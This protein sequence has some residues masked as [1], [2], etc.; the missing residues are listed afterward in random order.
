MPVNFEYSKKHTVFNAEAQ[1]TD[2]TRLVGSHFQLLC[3]FLL[4]ATCAAISS[5]PTDG[6]SRR[7]KTSLYRFTSPFIYRRAQYNLNAKYPVYV[8][9]RQSS[10]V[11]PV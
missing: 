1:F 9:R 3:L 11:F 4:K 10:L 5:T 7:D 6:V 2:L 8:F